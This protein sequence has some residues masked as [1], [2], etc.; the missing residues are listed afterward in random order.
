MPFAAGQA[1]SAWTVT[2]YDSLFQIYPTQV[3]SPGNALTYNYEYYGLGGVPLDNQIVGAL[4]RFIDP[5]TQATRY[6]YD[7]FGRLR[8]V[9]RPGDADGDP[10]QR[11]QYFD[12]TLNSPNVYL[13]PFLITVWQKPVS[14]AY[15]QRRF[16]NGMGQEIQTHTAYNVS[17]SGVSGLQ[18]LI[19]SALEIN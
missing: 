3:Q 19:V 12:N 8:D 7:V 1:A 13:N 10:S 6:T 2:T 5:N 17:L 11:Y 14:L 18:D 15:A 16:F 9:Y 4:K